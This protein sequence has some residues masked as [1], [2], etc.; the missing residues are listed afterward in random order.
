MAQRRAVKRVTQSSLKPDLALQRGMSGSPILD[1]T[2]AVVGVV[3]LT[4]LCTRL[5]HTLP[6]WL[7]TGKPI[8]AR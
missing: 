7:W 5:P 4:D 3:S 8:H 2:E 6:V 1:D